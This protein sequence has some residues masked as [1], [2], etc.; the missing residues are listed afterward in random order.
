MSSP[1]GLTA[2]GIG[3]ADGLRRGDA[4]GDLAPTDD[5]VEDVDGLRDRGCGERGTGGGGR[6]AQ[7]KRLRVLRYMLNGLSARF[8]CGTNLVKMDAESVK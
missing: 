1:L 5:A 8:A 3:T 7:K 6:L 2:G 4:G